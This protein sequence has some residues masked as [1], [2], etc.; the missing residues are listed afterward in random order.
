[1]SQLRDYQLEAWAAVRQGFDSGLH[2]VGISLPTGTGKTHIMAAMCAEMARKGRSTLTL[3]HRDTLVDQAY[4]RYADV[5]PASQIGIVK[6]GKNQIDRLVTIASVHT[7]SRENRLAQIFPPKLTIV[8]EAHVS[9][10]DMYLRVYQH[11]GLLPDA[12][13]YGVG[14]TATWLRSDNRGLGDIWESV[15][16]KRSIQWAVRRGYLVPPRAIQLGD[17]VDVSE[18]KEIGGDYSERGLEQ[19]VMIEDLRA[20]VVKGYL[21]MASGQPAVLFAPTQASARFFAAALEEAGIKTAEIFAGTS[22]L[23]RRVAFAGFHNG[24]VKVLVTCT[25]LA[26]GWDA[27]HCSVALLLR[28]SKHPGLITQCIGRVLRPWPGKREALL[29]DFVGVFDDYDMRAIIDLSETPEARPESNTDETEAEELAEPSEPASRMVR[30]ISGITQIDLFAGTQAR[31]LTTR[32]GIPFVATSDR[33]YFII[34]I[35]GAFNVGE[36]GK[37]TLHGG[38][39]LANNVTSAEAIELASDAAI[40]HDNTVASKAA[41]WRSGNITLKQES[42]ALQLGIFPEGMSKS[43][44]SDAISVKLASRVLD[45]LIV[46]ESQ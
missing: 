44:L 27:P 40:E 21:N 29:L 11:I 37:K 34:E 19:V 7:L 5:I 26:E 30:K 42:Y 13:G 43:E 35:D 16:Y 15:V 33:W 9:V 31:W 41:E 24:A 38:R 12:P 45:Q 17:G 1:M 22:P 39:W 36:C 2:R 14:F 23:A 20:T 4:R 6:A 28:P 18:V 3:V 25:A 8:D 32:G 46:K 10:S